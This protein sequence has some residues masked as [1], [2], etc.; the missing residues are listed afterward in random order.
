MSF[1]TRQVFVVF[2]VFGCLGLPRDSLSVSSPT[3]LTELSMWPELRS[4]IR[5]VLPGCLD[6]YQVP[7][8]A[9]LWV[10]VHVLVRAL[11]ATG[12]L[13]PCRLELPVSW[14]C[15]AC[16]ANRGLCQHGPEKPKITGI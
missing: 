14:H 5:A 2:T 8:P 13:S 3:F 9:L 1:S 7:L 12:P 4:S 10:Y 15:G 16:L 6:I 11:V